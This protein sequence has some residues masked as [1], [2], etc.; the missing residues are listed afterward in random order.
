[1]KPVSNEARE[2]I[3]KHWKNSKNPREIAGL[4]FR[5]VATVYRIIGLFVKNGNTMAKPYTGNNHKITAE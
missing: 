3:I 1:M 4:V 5:G 2:I